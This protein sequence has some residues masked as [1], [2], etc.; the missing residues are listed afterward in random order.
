[1]CSEMRDMSTKKLFSHPDGKPEM[2]MVFLSRFP[3]EKIFSRERSLSSQEGGGFHYS[4]GTN[5]DV[6]AE[7]TG[8]LH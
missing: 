2:Y 5:R 4:R 8:T 3:G 1:M 6:H 7:P